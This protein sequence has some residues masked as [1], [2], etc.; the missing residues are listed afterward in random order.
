MW[1]HLRLLCVRVPCSGCK[2]WYHQ[3]C[4][5]I[6]S[7]PPGDEPYY[8]KPCALHDPGC[9]QAECEDEEQFENKTITKPG[10]IRCVIC[11]SAT[12][13]GFCTVHD[14]SARKKKHTRFAHTSQCLSG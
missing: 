9:Q 6:P 5:G 12:W 14:K 2:E 3:S 7:V 13:R 1:L 10:A 8:C 4:Y 11:D